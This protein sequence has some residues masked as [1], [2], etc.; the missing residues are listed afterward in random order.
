MTYRYKTVKL[1]GKTKLLH[2]VVAEQK[3]G[4]PLRPGEHVHYV[5][6]QRWDNAPENLAALP[7]EQH[8]K[9]HAD[10]RLTHARTKLCQVCGSEFM[11]HPT[12]RKRAKTCSSPCANQLRSRTEKATKAKRAPLAAAMVAAQ[13]GKGAVQADLFS[14]AA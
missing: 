4:R 1:D 7:A 10:E 13:F 11:P 14:R 8:H 6:E 3:L 12:K 2:R 9:H 5:N